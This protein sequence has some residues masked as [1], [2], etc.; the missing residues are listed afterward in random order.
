MK[1]SSEPE[2]VIDPFILSLIWDD[3]APKEL[4]QARQIERD[5]Q[6][7]D[8]EEEQYRSETSNAIFGRDVNRYPLAFFKNTLLFTTR[9]RTLFSGAKFR[10]FQEMLY[11]QVKPNHHSQL[12]HIRPLFDDPQYEQ[13]R[14]GADIFQQRPWDPGA[15]R[16]N[17]SGSVV[18]D[19][20]GTKFSLTDLAML[21]GAA[22]N[23]FRF[24][25][26]DNSSD[27]LIDDILE[28]TWLDQQPID[29]AL[30][31]HQFI[32][33]YLGRYQFSFE[34]PFFSFNDVS[35]WITSTRFR[36]IDQ[37]E[38]IL[39]PRI[40][41]AIAVTLPNLEHCDFDD[42]FELRNERFIANYRRIV[43]EGGLD[44]L[45][46]S[47]VDAM[48]KQETIKLWRENAFGVKELFIDLAKILLSFVPVVGSVT[49]LGGELPTVSS[50]FRR[51][52][53]RWLWFVRNAQDRLEEMTLDARQGS[54]ARK[55]Q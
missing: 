1:W 21:Q 23:I 34:L 51:F 15:L 52:T 43:V 32:T 35:S 5:D 41:H 37:S 42:I 33:D 44:G 49:G 27:M 20:K 22:K 40:E 18:H 53:N 8:R 50:R 36:N 19:S 3:F 2:I 24:L 9:I 54:G 12:E 47:D 14:R 26:E 4:R 48:L 46:K 39:K 7:T 55:N 13:F 17:P 10:S 11:D 29:F 30:G 38:N 28:S 6:P 16:F 31:F 45:S 25:N